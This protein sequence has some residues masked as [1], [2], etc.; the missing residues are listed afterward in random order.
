[1]AANIKKMQEK[2][3]FAFC[4]LALILSGKFTYSA[5]GALLSWC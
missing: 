1:M 2:E 5:A 3:A 4:L